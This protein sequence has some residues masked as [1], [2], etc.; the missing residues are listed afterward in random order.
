MPERTLAPPKTPASTTERRGNYLTEQ[1]WQAVDHIVLRMYAD[2]ENAQMRDGL[3]SS[4]TGVL[5]RASIGQRAT[6]ERLEND[7][8]HNLT[9]SQL[10]AHRVALLLLEQPHMQRA[11]KRLD[12]SKSTDQNQ[13]DYP[14]RMN[15]LAM[16]ST[17]NSDLAASLAHMNSGMMDDF[18]DRFFVRSD[19]ITRRWDTEPVDRGRFNSIYA[20]VKYEVAVWRALLTELPEEWS[21]RHGTTDEDL[22]GTDFVVTNPQGQELRIDTKS[23]RAF[24]KRLNQLLQEGRITAEQADTAS[25]LGYIYNASRDADGKRMVNCIF[26]ADMMGDISTKFEYED[27]V[28]VLEFIQERFDDPP[29]TKRLRSLGKNAIMS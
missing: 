28:I 19:T 27:P 10:T 1:T 22:H 25:E 13:T 21:I 16:V 5:E 20:G 15:D 9:T 24:D 6:V 29:P 23:K 14:S 4:T 17:F 12:A 18:K 7:D 11:R 8:T 2:A 3:D 26:D